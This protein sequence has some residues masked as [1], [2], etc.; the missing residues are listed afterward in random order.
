MGTVL[1][2]RTSTTGVDALNGVNVFAVEAMPARSPP[3][4]GARIE[5]LLGLTAAVAGPTTCGGG[6]ATVTTGLGFGG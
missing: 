1:R 4:G 3:P 6:C 2:G 5:K